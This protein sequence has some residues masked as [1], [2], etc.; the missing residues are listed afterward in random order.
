MLKIKIFLFFLVVYGSLYP[1]SFEAPTNLTSSLNSLL[2][3]NPLQSGIADSFANFLLFVPI[4]LVVKPN[5]TSFKQVALICAGLFVF[6][7]AIQVVQVWSITRVPFGA[8]AIWNT[9]GAVGGLMISPF[10]KPKIKDIKKNPL[11]VK[12]PQQVSFLIFIAYVTVDLF[13]LVPSL[14]IGYIVENT[15]I[16]IDTE[17]LATLKIIKYFAFY[18]L[19]IFFAKQSEKL[20][21]PNLMLSLTLPVFLV[22]QIFI[23]SNTNDI[24]TALG[25]VA[26]LVLSPLFSRHNKYTVAF[27]IS[28]ILIVTNGLGSFEYTGKLNSF[29]LIPFAPALGSNTL[30]NIFAFVEKGLYYFSFTYLAIKTARNTL[31]ILTALPA[32][33][34]ILELLQIRIVNSTPDITEFLVCIFVSYSTLRWLSSLPTFS[35][36]KSEINDYHLLTKQLLS[37]SAVFTFALLVFILTSLQYW[38]MNQPN[39]PYNIAEM[40]VNSGS[41]KAYFFTSTAII[42]FGFG[43]AFVTFFEGNRLTNKPSTQFNKQ[44]LQVICV[45][46]ISFLLLRV[47]I[48]RETIADINGSSNITWQLTGDKIL[49]DFGVN[50]VNFFGRDHVYNISQ[51][52]EPIIRFALL[53]AP[54]AI[55]LSVGL[56]LTSLRGTT[57]HHNDLPTQLKLGLWLI[58]W[59][60]LS[61]VITFDYSSTDNLNELI[62]R[63]GAFGLGGGMYLYMLIAL[64][65]M[66]VVSLVNSTGKKKLFRM[67]SSLAFFLL[68]IPVSWTLL[69]NGLEDNVFKYGHTFSGIDFLLGGS[70]SEL[71]PTEQLQIRW[72]MIYTLI[73][74]GLTV[75]VKIGLDFTSTLNII[76]K[77]LQSEHSFSQSEF[78]MATEPEKTK[79]SNKKLLIKT[80]VALPAIGVVIGICALFTVNL[81]SASHHTSAK[82]RNIPWSNA[83]ATLILD[84]HTHTTYSDGSLTIDELSEK[85]KLSGCDV[86]AITDH[87]DSKRTLNKDRL[88]DIKLA[89][90]FH[91][92]LMIINGLEL[93]A[94]SYGKQEHI[95]FLVEPNVEEEFYSK[96]NHLML[97]PSP[98]P[99]TDR[100]LFDLINALVGKNSDS[101]VASYNHPSRKINSGKEIYNNYLVWKMDNLM[102]AFSGAP[103]HQKSTNIGSYNEENLTKQRW[104]PVTAEVGGVLDLLLDEGHDVFGSLAPSDY[105]NDKLDYSPCSFSKTHLIVPTNDYVGVFKALKNGTYWGSHGGFLEQYHFSVETS[106]TQKAL[107]P[108]EI[109]ETSKG[110]LVLIEV[111]VKRTAQHFDVPL[112]VDIFTNCTAGRPEILEA[113]ALPSHQDRVTALIPARNYGADTKSC[114]VRSRIRAVVDSEELFAFS[115]HVRIYLN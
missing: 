31:F 88:T 45:I 108:G 93:N 105:H 34:L 86:L 70:R 59:L 107:S 106:P 63:D 12:S 98:K 67:L 61:K 65:A 100:E 51:L 84:H 64:V 94:P 38:L 40:F 29:N 77:N 111:A 4:G 53:F 17:R 112:Q 102:N 5:F 28:F 83:N 54:L 57:S 9:L 115:N 47:G 15:K 68:S 10:L 75:T 2:S 66:V 87:T 71:L 80:F 44:L 20:A 26:S 85:A 95:N 82:V 49:G 114:Y 110:D 22:S 91:E 24:N 14:D 36:I 103:G 52:I 90:I 8:D 27:V 60:F 69:A 16:L 76:L 50:L 33:V 78:R 55:S 43:I 6:A 35:F 23:I 62:E 13:P 42:S 37:S 92:P 101:F 72:S 46:A 74:I 32:A 81:N 73:V 58:L 41:I 99:K 30:V 39:L 97:A 109:G 1:F 48:T 79:S 11:T 104:D 25:L 56:R 3:F 89:R 19:I 7:F 113:L 96:F 21:K 18:T